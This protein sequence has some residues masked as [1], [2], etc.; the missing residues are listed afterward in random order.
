M[1]VPVTKTKII[2]PR[3]RPD[4][5]SRSRLLDLFDEILDYPLTLISAPAGYGKTSFLIDLAHKADYP[6]SWF[7][8][9][10][11]DKDL[12]RFLYHFIAAIRSTFPN[13]G[14]RTYSAID[15]QSTTPIDL[16]QIIR[17]LVNDIYNNIS[18]HFVVILDD[19][20]L[21]SDNHLVTEFIN[22]LSQEMDDNCHLVLSSRTIFNMTDLP[23]MVGRSEVLGLSYEDLAF[24]ADEL[25]T[26][27]KN[28][29]QQ[30]ITNQESSSLIKESEG[31]ITG[32]LL[33]YET[34]SLKL[35]GQSR[36]ANVSGANLFNYLAQQ[37]FE[38][39]PNEIQ[40]FLL[41]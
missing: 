13:F 4:L 15:N 40:E 28:K 24:N 35:P 8:I 22:R 41:K 1:A 31:W 37:V 33:S 17:V 16:D 27:L 32:L 26:L 36:A 19:F 23:L 21:V 34:S 12:K 14:S 11:L 5:L 6:V 7:A 38:S 18:E 29:Y 25:K 20:H 30:T 39:Q 9:D 10:N 3:P 2:I